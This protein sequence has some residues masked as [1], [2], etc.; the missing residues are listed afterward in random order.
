MNKN[1]ITITV[2]ISDFNTNNLTEEEKVQ[3]AKLIDKANTPPQK[4]WWE[5][6]IFDI[7]K[8]TGY[9]YINQVGSPAPTVHT[10]D[11]LDRAS[12]RFGNA[13]EDKT[14]MEQRAKEIKCSNRIANFAKVVNGDWEADWSNSAEKKYY[15]FFAHTTNQYESGWTAVCQ[16]DGVTYFKSEELAQ[17][18]ID[19]VILPLERGDDELWD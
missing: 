17:R 19:E 13:C 4:E 18:C 7:K 3:L 1:K 15:I 2:D 11:W 10:G 5:D 16:E 9:Y 14:Y 12:L 8:G 6:T